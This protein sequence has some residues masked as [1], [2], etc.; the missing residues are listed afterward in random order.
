MIGDSSP[1]PQSYGPR[2][3]DNNLLCFAV[4]AFVIGYAV[5]QVP[6]GLADLSPYFTIDPTGLAI[7]LAVGAI[8]IVIGVYLLWKWYNSGM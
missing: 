6:L 7:A 2:H 3:R 4:I 1:P 5:I 8:P